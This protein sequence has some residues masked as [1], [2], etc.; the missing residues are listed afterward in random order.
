[1]TRLLPL[2]LADTGRARAAARVN[3]MSNPGFETADFT[4]WTQSG[5]TGFTFV[6][7]ARPVVHSGRYDALFGPSGLGALEQDVAA[8]PEAALAIGFWLRN[9]ATSTSVFHA[10]LNGID[11]LHLPDAPAFDWTANRFVATASASGRN[12]LTFTATHDL[13][14]FARDSVW[15]V[16]AS[17][18][19]WWWRRTIGCPGPPRATARL[20]PRRPDAS[21]AARVC[22]GRVISADR[23][24]R[25]RPAVRRRGRGSRRRW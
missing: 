5:D 17:R 1:M 8:A 13:S 11:L 18:Q 19:P 14:Y 20:T 2:P 21:V 15:T 24:A 25:C 4:G 7:A 6:N 22:D 3:P 9:L 16:V 12:T 10:A 23:P